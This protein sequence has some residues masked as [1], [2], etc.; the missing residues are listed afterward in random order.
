[1]SD[2]NPIER[3]AV[4]QAVYNAIGADLKTGVP[5]NLRGEVNAFYLDMYERTGAT[6]FEVRVNGMKCGTYGF[7]RVKGQPERTVSEVRVTDHDAMMA[8]D[9]PEFVNWCGEWLVDHMD[10]LAVQ[11]CAETGE[12]LDGVEVVTETIPATPD[13]I[14]PNGTLRVK[15]EKVAAALGNALPATIAGLLEGGN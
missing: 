15:P 3:L 13:T 2:L 9:S 10:E 4:E 1:V 14:R 12:L 11:Y 7:N 5:D 6:G 8:D